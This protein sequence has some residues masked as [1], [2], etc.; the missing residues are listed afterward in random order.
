MI[1][2]DLKARIPHAGYSKSFK[3]LGFSSCF[4]VPF[5]V[6]CFFRITGADPELLSPPAFLFAA[7]EPS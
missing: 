7:P 1:K 3:I 6:N 5:V 2:H 4:F